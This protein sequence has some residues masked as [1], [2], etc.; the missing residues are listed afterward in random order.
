[1]NLTDGMTV[2]EAQKAMAEECVRRHIPLMVNMK[3]IPIEYKP[4]WNSCG[5]GWI[6]SGTENPE[7]V[8]HCHFDGTKMIREI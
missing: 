7:L 6:M 1:M 3:I 2:L 4:V 8:T 5:K